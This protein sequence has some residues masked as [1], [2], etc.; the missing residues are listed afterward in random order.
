M[1]DDAVRYR[2]EDLCLADVSGMRHLYYQRTYVRVARDLGLKLPSDRGPLA[3]ETLTELFAAA[4]MAYRTPLIGRRLY[5]L[6]REA[7]LEEVEVKVLCAAD[8]TGIRAASAFCT[9]S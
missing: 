6:F 1:A 3:P 5:G 2:I 7:G 9:I 8:T 4:S